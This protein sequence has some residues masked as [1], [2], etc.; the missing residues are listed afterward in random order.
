MGQTSGYANW[1]NVDDSTALHTLASQPFDPEKT[2][3]IAS[4]TPVTQTP[5]TTNADPGAVA[6]SHYQSRDIVLEADAKTPSVLLL[7]DRTGD[8]WNVWVDNQ[9]AAV[10][11]CNYIMRGVFVPCGP[12]HH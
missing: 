1:T 5:S 3:L 8:D 2:V 12:S 11:R 10:L 9:P 6:I 7:N 4:D